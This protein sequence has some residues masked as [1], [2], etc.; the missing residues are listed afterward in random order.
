MQIGRDPFAHAFELQQSFLVRFAQ[1]F[2][3][4]LGFQQ[5]CV[6]VA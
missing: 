4:E 2:F 5:G 1:L 6:N 3:S